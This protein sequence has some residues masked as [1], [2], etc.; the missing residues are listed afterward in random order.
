MLRCSY[1]KLDGREPGMDLEGIIEEAKKMT[2]V[3]VKED[4]VM[5]GKE[6][7]ARGA[8]INSLG[9]NLGTL[10]NK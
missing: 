8:A 10:S 6:L 4:A 7:S 5:W 2:S 3:Q 1:C 9:R